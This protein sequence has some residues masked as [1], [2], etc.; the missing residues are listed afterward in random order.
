[1]ERRM[2]MGSRTMTR[3]GRKRRRKIRRGRKRS[4]GRKRTR[5]RRNMM[6]TRKS[7]VGGLRGK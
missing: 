2:K 1:M 6:I 7:N 3:K 5:R 4:R